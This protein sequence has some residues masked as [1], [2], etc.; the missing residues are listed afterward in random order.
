M[1]NDFALYVFLAINSLT[2][3]G[4]LAGVFYLFKKQ[5]NAAVDQSH[6][7]VEENLNS[8]LREI[9]TRQFSLKM[10]QYPVPSYLNKDFSDKGK[11][12]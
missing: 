4:T 2:S 6:D 5:K 3:F 7:K 1:N 9:Q 10:P 11:N 12:R 8:R